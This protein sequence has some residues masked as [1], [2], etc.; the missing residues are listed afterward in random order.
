MLSV[1]TRDATPGRADFVAASYP[2][3]PPS[4][5][6][7]LAGFCGLFLVPGKFT[8]GRDLLLRLVGEMVDGVLPSSYP[9]A[10][11]RPVYHGADV[12]LWFVNAVRNYHRYTSDADGVRGR[13]FDA[14][15][16]VLHWYAEGTSLGIRTDVD[17][18]LSTNQPGVP[19]TWMDAQGR[20]V[21]RHAPRRQGRRDQRPVAQR[22]GLRGRDGRAAEPPR[23][24]RRLR[25]PAA[26][27][28]V[29]F[30]R[31]FWNPATNGC[32]DTIDD[33]GADPAVRPNQLLAVS[34]AYPVLTPNRFEPVV[35][36]ARQQLMTPV[37][38]RTLSP[39]DPAYRGHYAGDVV[40][41]DRAYH[42]GSVHPWLLGHYVTAYLKVHGRG[43]GARAEARQLLDGCLAYLRDDGVGQLCELF[44]GG[45]PAPPRRGHRRRAVRRRV[46]AGLRSGRARPPA[47]RPVGARRRVGPVTFT[48]RSSSPRSTNPDIGRYLPSGLTDLNRG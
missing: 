44:D 4:P 6:A 9:E 16:S 35:E 41:R 47:G 5:R 15:V 22:P 39:A 17:G 31:R 48:P 3:A 30:N 27:A 28:K 14:V 37:G 8:A 43:A 38:P 24:G 29:A 11:G 10:G 25:P 21:G 42:Q 18:L 36:T 20:R 40:T 7:T 23:V 2:W 46:A 1:P 34:L 13:L 45:R 26:T 19:T 32:F 33:L 12:S